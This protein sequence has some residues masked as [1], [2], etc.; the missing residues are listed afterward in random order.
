MRER[1]WKISERVFNVS[2][3]GLIMGV[4]NSHAVFYC[5]FRWK[6]Q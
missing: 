2:R 5:F 4:L 6:K 1:I 3:Q